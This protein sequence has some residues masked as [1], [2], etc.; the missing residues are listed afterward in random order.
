MTKA[1]NIYFD[2]GPAGNKNGYL[3]STNIVNG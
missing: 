1:F 2:N 3:Q